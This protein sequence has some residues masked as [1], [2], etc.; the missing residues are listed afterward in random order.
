MIGCWK[1]GPTQAHHDGAAHECAARMAR[2]KH[3]AA[4]R[5]SDNLHSAGG[6]RTSTRLERGSVPRASA[7]PD[8]GLGVQLKPAGR[9]RRS[10][11]AL[12]HVRLK[13]KPAPRAVSPSRACA[14]GLGRNLGPRAYC[15]TARTEARLSHCPL[16]GTQGAQRAPSRPSAGAQRPPQKLGARTCAR[17][18]SAPRAPA[19]GRHEGKHP[20]NESSRPAATATTHSSARTRGSAT[21]PCAAP[22]R[23]SSARGAGTVKDAAD[24]ARPRALGKQHGAPQ[25][26]SASCQARSA[27]PRPSTEVQAHPKWGARAY[28]QGARI[29]LA[30]RAWTH[31]PS[32]HTSQ[33]SH[34]IQNS[35][36]L[37]ARRGAV[38]RVP[39]L[40]HRRAK[41]NAR[42]APQPQVILS[43]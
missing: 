4:Q 18:Q 3:A 34:A 30:G 26:A 25:R 8:A 14:H 29:T 16:P 2:R 27:L 33:K 24:S 9:D 11:T 36:V 28:Q 41:A 23:A 12:G 42:A 1:S 40:W 39:R 10:K 35:P 7:R 43:P 20:A 22:C 31:L 15:S 32:Y 13:A 5:Q 38:S 37:R 6:R 17:A 19:P 21:C